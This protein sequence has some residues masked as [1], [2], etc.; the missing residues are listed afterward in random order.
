M[1]KT[2]PW[3]LDVVS[4]YDFKRIKKRSMTESQRSY[5]NFSDGRGDLC[6]HKKSCL[7]MLKENCETVSRNKG[8]RQGTGRVRKGGSG[9][10]GLEQGKCS[11]YSRDYYEL[12]K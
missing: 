5:S 2:S 10:P 7:C 1:S 9:E 3:K 6:D 4:S 8:D 12:Y 11:T